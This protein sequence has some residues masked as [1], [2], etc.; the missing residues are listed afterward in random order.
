[1]IC[2]GT[3]ASIYDQNRM[4]YSP[5]VYFKTAQ[6]MRALFCRGAGSL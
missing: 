4:T 5:E 1:M 6:E 2:I 3:G